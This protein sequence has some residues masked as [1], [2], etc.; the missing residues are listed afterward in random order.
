MA[1]HQGKQHRLPQVPPVAVDYHRRRH[2]GRVPGGIRRRVLPEHFSVVGV[3]IRHVLRH[4]RAHRV[5]NLCLCGHRQRVWTV[6]AEPGV[7]GLL[8][9]GLLRL[10]GEARSG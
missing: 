5:H 7:L 9:A 3:P 2:H 4:R 1:E 10:A 6:G 8:S